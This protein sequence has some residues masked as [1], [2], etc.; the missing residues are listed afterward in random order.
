MARGV[1]DVDF[2]V[3]FDP[4]IKH[5]L[6]NLDSPLFI[7]F[8]P[9]SGSSWWTARHSQASRFRECENGVYF[10]LNVHT[11]LGDD[12]ESVPARG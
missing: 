6:S 8:D 9:I 2:E 5:F 1:L 10:A 4:Q 12:P 11:M 3:H 7:D